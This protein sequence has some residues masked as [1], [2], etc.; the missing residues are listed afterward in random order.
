MSASPAIAEY[1]VE[2]L[3]DAGENLKEKS[4]FN[5]IRPARPPRFRTMSH[6]E[7]QALV[8]T[9]PAYARVICRCENIT[10]A[11]IV[12]EIHAPIPATT[13]DAIKRRTW[14][15]TGRCQGGFDMPLVTQILA[16]ELGISEL[17]VSKRGDGSRFLFRGSKDIQESDHEA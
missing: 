5:P 16:R 7:R 10:E 13:Y 6:A 12:R 15:G 4:D 3:K 11:E 2:L 1:V 17:E 14:L 8:E 9:D